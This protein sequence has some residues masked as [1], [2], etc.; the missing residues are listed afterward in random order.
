MTN[1]IAFAEDVNYWK[2]SSSSAD[3]W[4]DKS[5]KLIESVGGTIRG[6]M[7]GEMDGRAAYVLTF[8]ISGDAF[9]LSWP[10]LPSRGGD[11]RAAQRQA[12]T[13]LYHDVKARV[14]A[15]KVLG[16]RTAFIP[17]LLLPTGRTVAESSAPDLVEQIPRLLALSE[18]VSR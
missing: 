13:M 7:F 12:A 9:R 18:G 8:E 1:E 17:W 4:I 14:V 5:R 11:V 10:V 2:S 3:S 16:E 6:F 15:A